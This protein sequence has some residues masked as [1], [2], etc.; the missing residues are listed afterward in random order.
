MKMN[1]RMLLVLLLALT[2]VAVAVGLML[3]DPDAPAASKGIQPLLITE[4]CAKNETLITDNFGRTPDYVELYNPGQDVDLTGYTFTDGKNTSAPLE[5]ITLKAGEYRVFFISTEHTGFALGA[6]GGDV[7]QLKD[8]AGNVVA[9]AKTLPAGADQVMLFRATGYQLS[10]LASPGFAN[11][12]AGREAYLQGTPAQAPQLLLSEVLVDNDG[13]LPD[14][15]GIFSDVV[16]L[17]NA[18]QSPVL[19]EDYWL[20]DHMA[21]RFAWRL[22]Q[23]TLAPGAYVTIIC[24]GENYTAPDGTIHAG[25]SLSRGETVVLT[26]RLGQYQS[27]KLEA[28]AQGL[29]L[30][31]QPDGTYAA[32]APSLGFE[33][34]QQGAQALAQ[35]RIDYASPLVIRELLLAQSG[36]AYE[37]RLQDVVEIVNRSESAQSTAGW[38]LSDGG[39]PYAYPLP[40]QILAPG[41]CMTLVCGPETTGFSLGEGEQLYLTGPSYRHAPPVQWF[42]TE[43]GNSLHLSYSGDEVVASQGPVSLGYENT[44]QGQ[45]QWLTASLPQ[46]LRISEVMTANQSYLPGSYG[47]TFDWVELYNPTDQPISLQG[48]MVASEPGKPSA[49]PLPQR[50]VNAGEYLVLIFTENTENLPVGFDVIPMSLSS[51]GDTLYLTQADQICDWVQLP[52]LAPDASYGRSSDQPGFSQLASATPG[53]ANGAAAQ[54]SAMPVAVTAQGCYQA[55]YLEVELSGPGPIYYTLNASTPGADAK[56][57]TGPI[58]IQSSTVIRAQCREPGKQPSQVLDLTYLLNTGDN[59]SVVTLVTDPANLWGWE[60]GIYTK[61]WLDVEVPA[62][63]SLFEKEGGGF[64]ERC[65][66]KMFGGF[67]REYDKKSFACMFRDKYGASSLQY[68]LFGEDNLDEFHAFVLR[69]G[70]QDSLKARIR[71]ELFTSLVAQYT[72]V[73]VQDYRPVTLYLNGQF[74]GVYFVRE[75]VNENFVAGHYNVR[76]EDVTLE[77]GNGSSLEY[78]ALIQYIREHDLSV[79]ANYDYVCSQMDIDE[80]IDFHAAQMWTGNV[81][82]GN[83][84]YFKTPEGKWTWILYDMDLAMG[85]AGY[86]SV[87]EQLNPAGTGADDLFSTELILALMKNPQFKD[88]FLRRMAWQGNTIWTRENLHARKDEMVALLEPDMKRDIAR[89]QQPLS[90]WYAKLDYLGYVIDNRHEGVYNRVQNYFGLSN[91]QMR[92]LG[93]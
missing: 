71:D 88:K 66:L 93:F 32:M 11:D 30:A 83:I 54:Q 43:L 38:F 25:F 55:E 64:T 20:S 35:S 26:D 5:A 73:P 6:T 90:L 19:L 61:Y 69:T 81:D 87:S 29:S 48:Y 33:N 31:W 47:R 34:S 59:L 46:G 76:P 15:R 37:Q 51:Q 63:V 77:Y 41:G 10:D 56:L 72:N 2:V 68:P 75:K 78:R 12:A 84:K 44:Q 1:N 45:Q 42:Q 23:R 70:G 74:W 85:V 8:G 80:Y 53:R 50:T 39:D 91:A 17:Y 22:P 89:W 36:V 16:E 40:E 9:Q 67:T 62:T 92:E 14:E 27:I 24:D 82:M 57:Y 65:G 13:A 4:I 7:I 58:R 28:L 60:K 3:P 52:A 86:D 49:C 18:S 21:G 79:Q